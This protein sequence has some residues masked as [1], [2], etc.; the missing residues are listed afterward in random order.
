MQDLVLGVLASAQN[1][2]SSVP[3][4]VVAVAALQ[5]LPAFA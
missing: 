4:R 3:P 1:L 5:A 2:T